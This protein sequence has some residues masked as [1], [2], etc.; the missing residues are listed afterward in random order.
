MAGPK[1]SLIVGAYNMS[2]ELPRTIRSLSPVMQKNLDPADCEII[3]V[4]NGSALPIDEEMYRG[5]GVDIRILRIPS[6][7]SVSPVRALNAAVAQAR[8]AIVGILIDGARI[9]S[10]GIVSLALQADLLATNVITLTLGFHLGF[11]VQMQSVRK[12]YDQ[13]KEDA[14]LLRSGW[15]EDGY[16]LFDISVFAGSSSRGWFLPMTESNA[17]FMRRKQWNELGGFDERFEAPGGGL[18]NLDLFSRAVALQDATVVTLLG[19]GTFHQV[20]G[21]VATNSLQDLSPLFHAEYEG[22]RGRPYHAPSYRS[23]YLGAIPGGAI[24]SILTSARV[25]LRQNMRHVLTGRQLVA[26]LKSLLRRTKRSRNAVSSFLSPP[27]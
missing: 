23:L 16:R 25:A 10:P 13:S 26:N 17:L 14:L 8:G 27:R 7:A 1:V 18:A 9:A 11:K 24:P 12:G 22:I 15:E 21:G 4:D 5:W 2:R 6:P 19:E 20:H 3:I